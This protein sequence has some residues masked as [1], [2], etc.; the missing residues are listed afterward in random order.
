LEIAI[1]PG[2]ISPGMIACWPGR[3][4]EL[5]LATGTGER[6]GRRGRGVCA[7]TDRWELERGVFGLKSGEVTLRIEK[8]IGVKMGALM[9]MWAACEIA[10]TGKRET[11]I[12]GRRVERAA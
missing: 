4:A 7:R 1:S 10:W 3:D 2:I 9:R 8:A 6:I 12:W 5:D 11:V